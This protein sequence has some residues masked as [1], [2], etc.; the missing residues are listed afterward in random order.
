MSEGTEM[1][2]E[3]KGLELGEEG[4]RDGDGKKP[5]DTEMRGLRHRNTGGQRQMGKWGPT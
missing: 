1:K 2:V 5:R 3:G 4:P